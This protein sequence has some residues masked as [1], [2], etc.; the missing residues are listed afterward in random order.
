MVQRR[1]MEGKKRVAE[2][3][4]SC[5]ELGRGRGEDEVSKETNASGVRRTQHDD[6]CK[7]SA[8]GGAIWK[9]EQKYHWANPQKREVP[10]ERRDIW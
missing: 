10:K 9:K 1:G 4:Q 2:A 6:G 7:E 8:A 3:D 5:T